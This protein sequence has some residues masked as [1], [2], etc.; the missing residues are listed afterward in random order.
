MFSAIQFYYENVFIFWLLILHF[1]NPLFHY[2]KLFLWHFTGSISVKSNTKKS[3]DK[4]T[5]T[6]PLPTSLFWTKI[7]QTFSA[8]LSDQINPADLE[9]L[10]SVLTEK[11]IV[12]ESNEKKEIENDTNESGNEQENETKDSIKV[13]CYNMM[14]HK[15]FTL[16]T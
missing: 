6:L 5:H 14:Y 15:K 12:H 13:W 1:S 3:S 7:S 8:A 16:H 11:E 2:I 4:D 10:D 9:L